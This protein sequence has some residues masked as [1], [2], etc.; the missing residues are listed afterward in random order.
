MSTATLTPAAGRL[1]AGLPLAAE[2]VPLLGRL[3]LSAIFV[4]S[5]LSKAAAPAAT[6]GYIG[7]VGLP[8]PELG[9]AAAVLVEVVG[10]LMLALGY[11][12]RLAAAAIAV[13]T[14]AAAIA[15]HADFGDQ[16]QF[17]HF[18]K[19][20]ALAGGLAQVVAFGA[21]RLSLDALRR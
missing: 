2:A 8:L 7:A 14:V 17:I 21:G 1:S 11:H 13:F 5:G 9:F 20:I 15:F 6:I 16:N 12:T 4:V 18:M 19:N 3:M 10:G